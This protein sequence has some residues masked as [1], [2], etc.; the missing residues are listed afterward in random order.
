[1]TLQTIVFINKTF[2]THL[3]QDRTTIKK[4]ITDGIESQIPSNGV[5]GRIYATE[6]YLSG[7]NNKIIKSKQLDYK[8]RP[9]VTLVYLTCHKNAKVIQ[10]QV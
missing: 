10:Q 7:L 5:I 3:D 4:I 8:S 1:M 6:L 2:A 9:N